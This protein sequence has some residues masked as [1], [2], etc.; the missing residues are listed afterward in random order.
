MITNADRFS[1]FFRQQIPIKTLYVHIFNKNFHLTF[2]KL[3]HYL[4]KFEAN[5]LSIP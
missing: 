5:I 1:K 3:L 2:T 4:V